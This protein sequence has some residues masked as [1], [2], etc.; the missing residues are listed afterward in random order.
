MILLHLQQIPPMYDNSFTHFLGQINSDPFFGKTDAKIFLELKP[1][2]ISGTLSAI[3]P[4]AFI[5]IL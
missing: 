4:I 5:L 3:N 1:A 2:I